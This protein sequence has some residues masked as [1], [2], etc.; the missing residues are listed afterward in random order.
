MKKIALLLSLMLIS[1]FVTPS[2]AQMENK[3]VHVH[4]AKLG[5]RKPAMNFILPEKIESKQ[6]FSLSMILYDEKNKKN[7]QHV[8]IKLAILQNDVKIPLLNALFYDKNGQVK[9]DFKYQSFDKPRVIVQAP[10]ETYLGGYMSEFGSKIVARQNVFT[11]GLYTLEATVISIDS[12]AQFID[13]EIVFKKEIR[14]GKN[15]PKKSEITI[16]NKTKVS[17]SDKGT[18]EK[19]LKEKPK[20]VTSKDKSKTSKDKTKLKTKKPKS[21]Y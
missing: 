7:F 4:P 21:S 14:I 16:G 6:D 15:E 13:K 19:S 20:K 18:Q 2:F 11:D 8:T 3:D 9:I 10:Q 1:G 17:D 12:P 5:D